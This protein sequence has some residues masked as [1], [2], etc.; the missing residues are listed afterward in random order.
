M[1]GDDHFAIFKVLKWQEVGMMA[2]DVIQQFFIVCDFVRVRISSPYIEWSRI[3]LNTKK[4]Q[5]IIGV[6]YSPTWFKAALTEFPGSVWRQHV[7]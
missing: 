3:F 5:L 7:T 4:A 2:V 1:I 6:I